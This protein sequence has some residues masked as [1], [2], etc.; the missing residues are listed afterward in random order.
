M[1]LCRRC[2]TYGVIFPDG[3]ALLFVDETT[4]P[5][6]VSL[7]T[8]HVSWY[9]LGNGWNQEPKSCF[10]IRYRYDSG[11]VSGTLPSRCSPR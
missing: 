6:Y 5:D 11:T 9:N 7:C 1:L 3:L 2:S 4:D 8:N 10:H